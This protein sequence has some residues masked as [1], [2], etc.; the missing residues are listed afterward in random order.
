MIERTMSTMPRVRAGTQSTAAAKAPAPEAP[1]NWIH[2]RAPRLRSPIRERHRREQAW[3]WLSL[4]TLVICWD[5]SE[6]LGERVSPPR[7]R[8]THVME[9]EE[10]MRVATGPS[11]GFSVDL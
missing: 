8:M 11:S 7:A 6:R 10:V 3:A 4:V 5:A 2:D 1:R 9:D